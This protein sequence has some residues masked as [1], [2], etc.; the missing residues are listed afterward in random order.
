MM[1]RLATVGFCAAGLA[2]TLA[3]AAGLPG[4]LNLAPYP[5]FLSGNVAPNILVVYDN[6][7]SMDGTMAG[8]VIAGSDPTTRGNI[9]RGVITNTI[10]SYRSS[11]NWGLASFQHDGDGASNPNG[12]LYNTFAYYFGDSSTPPSP[13]AMVFTHDCANGISVSNAGARCIANPQPGNGYAYITYAA[14]GDDPDINDVLY[15]GGNFTSLW[16]IGINGTTSYNVYSAR[17]TTSNAT[18]WTSGDFNTSGC[19]ICG[20]WGF[21][22][23]D[24]GFL[25]STPPYPRQFWVPRAWG[26]LNNPSGSARIWE[27]VQPD[28]T[29]HYNHMMTLLAPETNVSNSGEIKNASVFTPLAGSMKTAGQYFSGTSGNTSPITLACQKNFVLLA[30]D[31]NP[32]AQLDG[33]MYPT[34]QMVNTYNASTGTWTFSQAAQ[35]VFSKVTSLRS[36]T[37]GGNPYDVQTYVV[38]LGDT[39]QNAGSVA[40]LNQ[41]AQLGGTGSAYLAAD[42]GSLSAAFATISTDIVNKVASDSSVALNTGSWSSTVDLYQARFSSGGWTGQLLAYPIASTGQLG[43]QAWD[44]GQV[45]NGQDWSSGRRVLTNKPSAAV[46][47]Q[48][49][50]FRWPLNPSSPTATE[51]DLSQLTALNTGPTGSVDG[52]GALRLQ[53]LRGQRSNEQGNC[54]TCTPAFR[55]RPTSV[56]G[57][58]IDSAPYYVAAPAYGY[59][60]SMESVPYSSFVSTYANRS[61]VIYVG[62]ND[63]MLHAFAA[64]DGHEAM[65]Y[66]PASVYSG[67]TQLTAPTYVHRFYVDG[68]PTVGDA[69]YG[70]QWHTLLAAGLRAGGQGVYAL[71]VTDPSS[72]SEGNAAAVVRWEFTDANDADLGYTFGQPLIVKTN[73]G[74]WSVIVASGYDS[75]QADAHTSTSG[76]AFLFVL[77]AQTGAVTAKI[78]TGSGTVASPNGL[79]GAIAIDTDGSGTADV[80]YAGDLLGNL[81]KFDLSSTSPSAWKVAYGG[82]LFTDPNHQPITSRPEVT[83]YPGG[84]YLVLFGTGRYIDVTD[85]TTTNVETFY[86]IRD[87]GAAVSG[88]STLVKQSVLG[89]AVGADG[90]TYRI[91]THAVGPATLDAVRTG[92]NTVSSTAYGGMN[93]WYMTLPDSG[94]RMIS[95]PAVRS[96]RVVFVTLEPNTATCSYGGSGWVMDVDVTTGNRLGQVTFDTNNDSNLT[97]ADMLTFGSSMANTSGEKITSIPADPGF[98]RMPAVAGQAPTE[99]KYINT[100]SGQ[101]AAPTETAGNLVNHRVS[102][103]QLQ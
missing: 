98:M 61:P 33:S 68:S 90:N 17:N 71:D 7:E 18:S 43:S 59:P 10:S 56:L 85:T 31:G 26:Y 54:P 75:T 96:G 83:M 3:Q 40:T 100:S 63:G 1:Q 36:T 102:W 28:S 103:E 52:Y 69:F 101:I 57:D 19:G 97:S 38:G 80:V 23:T 92:D 24:A 13:T 21:T 55:S 82:P 20:T 93:G 66:V 12:T 62:G 45:L 25:P 95:D 4:Y 51:L 64:S 32:T 8:K 30:T 86:G 11:F 5:L 49:I 15:Y 67:L 46:G 29:T 9:A 44:S 72:F 48:G 16:G 91:T 6:S 50:A 35:D 34:A 22:P 87:N 41:I 27:K 94:E 81:W 89:S 2:T 58:L 73:N 77:D 79:S 14:S 37:F 84:G 99:K 39:V 65:A 42:S 76:D 47:A 74:R 88:T 53:F 78:A 60:D 70:S